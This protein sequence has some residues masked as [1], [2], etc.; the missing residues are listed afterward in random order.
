MRFKVRGTKDATRE[1]MEIVA[2]SPMQ[3]AV[4]YEKRLDRRDRL[5]QL[6]VTGEC[7]TESRWLIFGIVEVRYE[8]FP[9]DDVLAERLEGVR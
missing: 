5:A 2:E 6:T 8:P 7:G 1:P 3:A 4:I 9:V